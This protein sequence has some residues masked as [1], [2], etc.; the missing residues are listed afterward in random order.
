MKTVV[1]YLGGVPPSQKTSHKTDLL[2]GFV[3]G[4]NACGDRGITWQGNQVIN[5]NVGVIQGWVHEG[6]GNAKHLML[7][8]AVVDTHKKL[9][10]KTVITDSNLF[11]YKGVDNVLWYQRYSLDGVFP[12][13]GVYFDREIDPKRWQQIGQD[14]GMTLKDWRSSGNH[15]LICTQR[16]GGW[17]MKGVTVVSWLDTVIAQ[18]RQFSDRPIIVRP[19]PGDKQAAIYLNQPQGKYTLSTNSTLVEDLKDCWAVVTYNSSPGVAAAIEGVPIFITDPAPQTS[20]AFDVGNFNLADIERPQLKERQRWIEKIS[21][22]HWKMSELQ[23]GSAWRHMRN[24]V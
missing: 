17:S 12:T 10:K 6:S 1:A 8:K 7:R 11:N 21:M 16:N 4:V 14:L 24:Y 15:I 5:A 3:D 9:N 20:Q 19:H 22:C 18:I 13:T 2:L 23:D